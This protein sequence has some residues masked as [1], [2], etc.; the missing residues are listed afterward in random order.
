ML[1]LTSLLHIFKNFGER[2]L[3]FII[4]TLFFGSSILPSSRVGLESNVEACC[5]TSSLNASSEC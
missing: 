1:R 4:L 2:N 5:S 3:V